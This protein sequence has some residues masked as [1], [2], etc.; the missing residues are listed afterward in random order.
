VAARRFISGSRWLRALIQGDDEF[1]APLVRV[2]SADPPRPP[3]SSGW[4]MQFDASPWGGGA[5]LRNGSEIKEYFSV[6]WSPKDADHLGIVIGEPA[7]QTFWEYATLV[8]GLQVWG[9]RFVSESL[10]V[11]GDN[12]GSLQD[13]LHLKGRGALLAL[14]REL[15]WRQSRYGWQFAVGHVPSE[16][17]DVSDC[18]S[19]L[20]AYPAKEFPWKLLKD[21]AEVEAPTLH[22]LWRVEV[23]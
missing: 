3:S 8:I 2:V 4:A 11:L 6:K 5:L 22:S 15:S 7:G 10:A 20:F 23:P 17:N 19:R 13:A 14:S 12:T 1:L 18:L 21:A 16:H 9:S